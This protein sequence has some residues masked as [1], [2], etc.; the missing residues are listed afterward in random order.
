MSAQTGL[1]PEM[2]T[3]LVAAGVTAGVIT[4][5]YWGFSLFSSGEGGYEGP[6]VWEDSESSS[7]EDGPSDSG[8]ESSSEE[9]S[10]SED[11]GPP[12]TGLGSTLSPGEEEAPPAVGPEPAE[13]ESS[14]ESE[15]PPC[16]EPQPLEETGEDMFSLIL[17]CLEGVQNIPEPD[18]DNPPDSGPGPAVEESP[19]EE[20]GSPDPGSESSSVEESPGEE[21]APSASGSQ[22]PEESSDDVE[23]LFWNCVR[24]IRNIPEPDS[25]GPPTNETVEGTAQ[26]WDEALDDLE[27]SFRNMPDPGSEVP[28]AS[29]PAPT[30]EIVERTFWNCVRGVRNIPEPDSEDEDFFVNEDLS[31]EEPE[32]PGEEEIF[33]EIYPVEEGPPA[34]EPAPMDEAAEENLFL[35]RRFALL[36]GET[37]L[38][39]E[40]E[41][42]F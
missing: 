6:P 40:G 1:S 35:R 21:E 14:S 31:S 5:V 17:T 27:E 30:N 11:D 33:D 19:G 13:E 8:Y 32:F 10:S 22:S 12:D 38:Q 26:L 39:V 24:G 28:P 36:A 42:P 41:I 4:L 9:E 16:A 29:G 20:E 3:A 7:E 2:V 34:S 18:F 23:S 37:M 25:E 15:G